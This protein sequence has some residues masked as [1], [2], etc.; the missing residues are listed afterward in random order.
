MIAFS[1]ACTIDLS[2][3]CTE[4]RRGSGTLIGRQLIER[5]VAAIGVGLHVVEQMRRR[6]AGAQAAELLLEDRHARPAC[7][8]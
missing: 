7:G 1:T 6:P 2:H 4:M 3:T 8:A 5:H